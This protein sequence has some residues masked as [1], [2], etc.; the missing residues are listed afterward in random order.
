MGYRMDLHT[1]LFITTEANNKTKTP[2]SP[3]DLTYPYE[4]SLP[5]LWVWTTHELSVFH[6]IRVMFR[7]SKSIVGLFRH[8]SGRE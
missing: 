2:F 8:L 6:T 4:P 7:V 3:D 5:S 1:L